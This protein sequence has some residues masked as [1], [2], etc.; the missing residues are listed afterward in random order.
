MTKGIEG[1]GP[2][3]ASSVEEHSLRNIPSE[4]TVVRYSPRTLLFRHDL[5]RTKC[6][7]EFPTIG[8]ATISQPRS[9][10]GCCNLSLSLRKRNVPSK[11]GPM[12]HALRKWMQCFYTTLLRNSTLI[13]K[14]NASSLRQYQL[15]DLTNG[16]QIGFA[17]KEPVLFWTFLKQGPII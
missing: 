1:P 11:I 14:T 13:Y 9:W 6:L 2:G 3:P 15:K 12:T 8:Q 7:T 16:G 17:F 10:K 4:G 5:F